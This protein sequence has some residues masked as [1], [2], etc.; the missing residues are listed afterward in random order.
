MGLLLVVRSVGG[1]AD[2]FSAPPEQAALPLHS[3]QNSS[4]CLDSIV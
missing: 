2:Q 1:F 4:V 3:D